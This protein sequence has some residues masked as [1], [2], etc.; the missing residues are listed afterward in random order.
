MYILFRVQIKKEQTEYWSLAAVSLYHAQDCMGHMFPATSFIL[1]LRSTLR[2]VQAEKPK[3]LVYE[4]NNS[5]AQLLVQQ[6]WLLR[7]KN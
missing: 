7:G 6:Q 5:Q 4:C 2:A 1:T 3:D